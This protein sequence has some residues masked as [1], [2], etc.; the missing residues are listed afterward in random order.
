MCSL[1]PLTI[2]VFI[3]PSFHNSSSSH[4]AAFSGHGCNPCTE[5]TELPTAKCSASTYGWNDSQ[6]IACLKPQLLVVQVQVLLVEREDNV[7]R[8]HTE[9]EEKAGHYLSV[10]SA[11]HELQISL[12]RYVSETVKLKVL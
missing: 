8:Y 5:Y 12:K 1:T 2:H 6:L 7:F 10:T 3:H 4:L 11:Q 9:P